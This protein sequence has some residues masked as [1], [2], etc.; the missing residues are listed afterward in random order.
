MVIPLVPSG[1]L[2]VVLYHST[3][4]GSSLFSLM[5]ASSVMKR[6]FTVEPLDII[7]GV[8]PKSRRSALTNRS[9]CKTIRRD[10]AMIV[11]RWREP[12]GRATEEGTEP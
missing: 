9:R 4:D 1:R 11:V 8:G 5:R 12:M 2:T 6:H 3:R 7:A 10:P